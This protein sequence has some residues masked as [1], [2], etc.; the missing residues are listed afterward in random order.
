MSD[1]LANGA[2]AKGGI[3]N[4]PGGK[5][6]AIKRTFGSRPED[7]SPKERQTAITGYDLRQ[8]IEALVAAVTGKKIK[9]T[10]HGSGAC[11]GDDMMILPSIPQTHLFVRS[12]AMTLLG[13][14]AH[15]ISHQLET[16]F[17]MIVTI[18]ADINKPTK[19]EI[20]LKEWWNAIEDYRIEKLTR[21]EFPGFPIYIGATRH[22]TA[23]RFVASAKEGHFSPED[24]ANPYRLG[25]VG[26]TWVGAILN[27]YPTKAHEE[28]LGLLGNDLEQWLRDISPRLAKVETKDE[29]LQLAKDLLAELAQNKKDEDQD[30][31][32]NSSGDQSDQKND[33]QQQSSQQGDGSDSESDG[34]QGDPSSSGEKSSSDESGSNDE[35]KEGENASQ[36]NGDETDSNSSEEDK[37]DESSGGDNDAEDAQG[38]DESSQDD[39]AS[40]SQDSE[41]DTSDTDSAEGSGSDDEEDQP[42]GSDESSKEG[43]DTESKSE[44]GSQ[45][46]ETDG[47]ATSNEDNAESEDGEG[48]DENNSSQEQSDASDDAN[49][50]QGQDSSQPASQKGG[51]QAPA[52]RTTSDQAQA[53]PEQSDLSIED[54]L[55]ALSQIAG[56]LDNAETTIEN[57]I[58]GTE[59]EVVQ[60]SQKKY[61]QVKRTVGSSAA[62]TSGVVR[63]LLLSKNQ[64]RTRR[65]LEQ[66][67]LDLKR[68]VPI[69]NGSPNIY[70]EKS[71]RKDV[72]SAVSILLDNSSSMSGEPILICQKAAVVLDSAIN[73]TGTD[74]EISGFTGSPHN[75]VIYQYRRFGQRGQAA[76][77]SLGSM[78]EVPMGGTPVAVPIL[79]AHRRLMAHK[80]PRKIMVVISDG[81]ASDAQKA[82]EAHDVAIATGCMVFGIG[83]GSHG[84]Y[85][86]NWCENHQVITDIDQ[87]PSALSTIVQTALNTRTRKAA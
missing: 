34:A 22:F 58:V 2:P 55:E 49:S 45:N 15:E 72:N 51:E 1:A 43:D 81:A 16:D 40:A 48:K 24:L 77:A 82:K 35:P 52:P 76:A 14:A 4:T 64:T 26:L 5:V 80:A 69:A 20:Q 86:A 39:G 66:G 11:T 65:N 84:G 57:D 21:R 29:A 85:I 19:E 7:L 78:D 30:Q 79:E 23:D 28:A 6:T 3:R 32:Q 41:E 87:L 61:A 56:A 25:A 73:G 83:I 42:S 33:K 53:E 38:K 59:R 70:F 10:F 68:L 37:A 62:R 18:F 50:Q 27:G 12:E 60:R 8:R 44:A 31:S 74:L 67:K 36:E 9:T 47:N 17:D 46:Q 54:I 71:N 13:Y 63:R 75:P